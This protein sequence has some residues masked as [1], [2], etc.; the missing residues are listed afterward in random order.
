ME[1]ESE[2]EMQK[3]LSNIFAK[4]QCL[5]DVIINYEEFIS[6]SDHLNYP[7]SSHQKIAHSFLHCLKSFEN[8][9]VLVEDK[10]I[11]LNSDDILRPDF[12]LYSSATESIIIVELKNQKSSTRQTATEIGAYAAELRSYL[13]FLSE[14]DLV[15]VIVSSEWPT[16]L[17]HF[18]YNEI[19]WLHK[20]IIC[21]EPTHSG[22]ERALKIVDPYLIF[23]EQMTPS[24]SAQQLGG[25]QICLYDDQLY[26]GGDYMRL[27]E[28]ENSMFIALNAM[29]AKGNSLKAHGFAF[30]WRH[31]F[32]VGFAPYNITVM[33]FASFQ[34][35]M[36]TIENSTVNENIF[37]NKLIKAI[38]DHNPEGH[39]NTLD[40]I[41]D[42][43]ETFLKEFCS[44]RAEGY[45]NWQT[46]KPRIFTEIAIAFVGWG[47]FQD[48]L[49]DRLAKMPKHEEADIRFESTDP[50]FAI[51]M[52]NEIIT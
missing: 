30:L 47:Y 31:R 12:L 29:S 25:Y 40:I 49:F 24:I 8:H 20:R 15:N 28:F 2:K 18:T 3:W 37:S 44:P 13:P 16:L 50:L 34:T 23:K 14:G 43:A 48:R 42:Y 35:P 1:F 21:L 4:G 45:S 5:A 41:S 10:N 46:L 39:S 36:L 17:C 52:L 27:Q 7:D 51:A 32:D 9:E 11:S 38:H 6:S 19:V 26:A 22:G 33:N